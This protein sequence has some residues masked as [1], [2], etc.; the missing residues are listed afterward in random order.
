[1]HSPLRPCT[2]PATAGFTLI[3]M[4]I[5]IVIV[6]LLIS[7]VVT[8]LPSLIQSAKIKKARAELERAD[9]AIEGYVAANG[10]EPCPDTDGDGLENRNDGGT[11]ATAADDSCD[12]YSGDLPYRTLGLSSGNDIWQNTLVYSVYEGMIKTN[13]SDYC[14]HL[15]S[16]ISGPDP[17]WLRT[18]DS[19]GSTNQAYVLVS[20]GPKDMDGAN[21]FFD[22]RNGSPGN[23]EFEASNRIVDAAYDDLVRAG[24]LSYLNGRLCTGSGGGGGGGGS[25]GVENCSNGS[26]DDGDAL[27]DCEDPDCAANVQ[28]LSAPKVTLIGSSLP[29]SIIGDSLSHTFQAT[30]GESAPDYYWSLVSTPAELSGKLSLNTWSG[31][32]SATLDVCHSN[33]PFTVRVKAEDRSPDP[34]TPLADTYDERDFEIQVTQGTLE[35]R[36]TPSELPDPDLTV[37][38]TAFSQEFSVEGDYVGPFEGAAAWSIQWSG[39]DP[40]GF[41]IDSI[42]ATRARFWKSGASTAGDFLFSLTAMDDGCSANTVTKG[43]YLLRITAGGAAPPY[44]EGMEAEWRFDACAPWDGSSFDVVD[45]LGDTRHNGKAMGAAQ[46][47][48]AGKICNAAQFT[49]GADRIVSDVLTGGDIMVFN[50]A[51]TLACWFKSPG[52]GTGYPRLIEFSNAAGEHQYSTALAY[53]TDGSLRAWV[54]SSTGVRGAQIDWSAERYNDNQWHHAVY[55]YS[56]G[57]GGRL[58][59]DGVLKQTATDN[60]TGDIQDAETFVMGGYYPA[61]GHGFVGLLDEVMVFQRE[62]SQEEVTDLSNLTRTACTDSC[63]S[64]PI[65]DYQMENFPW[66]ASAGEVIDNGSAGNDGVAAVAD[67]AATATLPQLPSQTPPSGGKTCR[68]A[69]LTRDSSSEGGYLDL[70]DPADGSLDP[71]TDTWTI[72]AW[73]NWDGT[74]GENIIYNKE[75]LFEAAVQS[76]YLRFAWQPSWA[77]YGGTNAP[78][79]PDTWYYVTTLFTG[80]QQLLYLNGDLVFARN[81]TGTIGSNSAKLLIGARGSTTPYSFFGGMIDE[82][83][84]WDRGLAENEI[85]TDMAATRD[86]TADS[87]VINTTSLPGATLGQTG[88]SSA[89][90]PAAIGGTPPYVWQIISQDGLSLTMPDLGTGVLAGDIDVCAGD[91]QITLR[92]TDNAGRIDEAALPLQVANG[93]LSVGDLPATLACTTSTCAW[94]LSVSGDHVGG[95]TGWAID[96]QGADP[97][98]FEIV[99]TGPGTARLRKSGSSTAGSNYRF[100]LTAVDAS[101]PSNTLDTGQVYTLNVSGSG[102]EVPYT[103]NLNAEWH[104]DECTWDGSP[105]EVVD[106]G[107]NGHHGVS[108]LNSSTA[109]A[110]R[111]VG[112]ICRAAALNIGS[113][114]NEYVGLGAGAFQNLGDFSLA[115]WF[116]IDRLSSQYNTLFSGAASGSFNQMLLMLNPTATQFVTYLANGATGSFNI[117]TTAADGLWHHVVWTRQA[118]D[119]A[120]VIYLDG[121]PLTDGSGAA[122]TATISLAN[123]GALLGQEQDSVGG[124]FALNQ[125]FQGWI[126]EVQIFNTRLD[127]AQVNALVALTHACSVAGSCYPDPVG[128]YRLDESAWTIGQAD[129]VVNTAMASAHGTALGSTAVETSDSQLCNAAHLSGNNSSIEISGLP[130]STLAGDKTSVCFWMKWDG[131]GS[132]MPVGWGS[133]YDLYFHGPTRFGFNTGAGDVFG[134]SGADALAGDWHHVCAVFTNSGPLSNQLYIDGTLQTS[135]VLQGTPRNQTVTDRL[136]LGSWGAGGYH[137]DGRLD[138]VHV[139]NRGLSASEVVADM[140]RTHGCSGGL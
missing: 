136:V 138:E 59:I 82:V 93:S 132:E 140:N 24:S 104:L 116:R 48:G 113:N 125:A 17:S 80:T 57:N 60:L 54:A 121:S 3:E 19:L 36:P 31:A 27:I 109:D 23:L 6:G 25:G 94:D 53:D 47:F 16:F 91:Y 135:S 12:A 129:A 68:S 73:I 133:T 42:D 77:W 92:V 30:G 98:G 38:S 127:Q 4:A 20:G 88:Y 11:T 1:M 120:E 101:C 56:Q 81:E 83:R 111:Q 112:K 119:G 89:P 86:C 10:R 46:I 55:T 115:L 64:A 96:W 108:S 63:Y 90:A 110:D 7:I 78:I 51:V 39:T 41:Q 134:I 97:G 85:L 43:P 100:G 21:G 45:A 122:S 13:L 99:A 66:T 105:G 9:F 5:V 128:D 8:V 28:C 72:S 76:G 50:D 37:D 70:G 26:D 126:D 95:L 52:G 2:R 65:G 117:G 69:I 33:S 40:G 67:N 106:G 139:Y 130:V 103:V 123:G 49:G 61:A 87:V 58:Y 124:G 22:D 131:N 18:T 29:T 71:G 35:I 107:D 75:N 14:S 44:T 102:V 32:L 62:L 118:S 79:A 15:E 84:I 74:A 114:Q 137:Y 34:S